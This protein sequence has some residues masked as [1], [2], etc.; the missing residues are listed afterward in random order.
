MQRQPDAEC[1][2]AP[3]VAFKFNAAFVRAHES[4]R[5]LCVFNMSREKAEFQSGLLCG[6]AAMALGCGEAALTEGT[7]TLAPLS[8]WFA[9]L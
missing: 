7:L 5:V 6:A 8:A 3:D 2:A 4:E 9:R 1:G